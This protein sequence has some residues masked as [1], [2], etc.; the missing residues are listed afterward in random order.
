MIKKRTISYSEGIRKYISRFYSTY[1]IKD[2]EQELDVAS[3][4]NIG[5]EDFPF[6][7]SSPD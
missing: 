4:D 2:S 1:Y 6:K 5:Q 3:G 7:K